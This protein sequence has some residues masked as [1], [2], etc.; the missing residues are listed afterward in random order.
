MS[1]DTSVDV[2]LI[3]CDCNG[4]GKVNNKDVIALFGYVSGSV[5]ASSIDVYAADCSG[6]G[7]VA[8]S[9]VVLLFR[10]VSGQDAEMHYGK[11]PE[12]ASP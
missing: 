12:K 11:T 8:N 4:D 7:N 6:D 10:Y 5:N 1:G 9:D 2:D 3:A